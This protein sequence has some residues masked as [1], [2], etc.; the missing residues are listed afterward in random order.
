MYVCHVT[1]SDCNN[2][3]YVRDG[4]ESYCDCTL[5][6]AG[7]FCETG[8]PICRRVIWYG[9]PIGKKSRH[10]MQKDQDYLTED[11]NSDKKTIDEGLTRSR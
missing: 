4:D 6:Y 2:G 8:R 9:Y 3:E 7:E 11:E 10:I 1:L 5:G